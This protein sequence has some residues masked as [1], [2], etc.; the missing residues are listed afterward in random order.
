MF[1]SVPVR[2][3]ESEPIDLIESRLG[4]DMKIF[5]WDVGTSRVLSTIDCH[6]DS[7]LSVSWNYNGSRIVTS[8]KDK[9]FRVID[10]RTAEV[11]K[12]REMSFRSMGQSKEFRLI[13]V[14]HWSSGWKTE[15]SGL[16]T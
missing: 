9:M 6:P 16:F 4:G 7:I 13:A 14:G 12:V 5:I 15:S 8:C 3:I 2:S 1:C 11:V 10:P